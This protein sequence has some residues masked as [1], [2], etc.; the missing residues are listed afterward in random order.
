MNTRHIIQTFQK[1][2]YPKAIN[3]Y[4]YATHQA[5]QREKAQK[6]KVNTVYNI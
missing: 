5:N 2:D 6:V 4:K 3:N 1:D